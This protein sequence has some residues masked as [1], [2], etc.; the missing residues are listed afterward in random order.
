MTFTSK[1]KMFTLA[2]N[3]QS[4]LMKNSADNTNLLNQSKA[5]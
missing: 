5:F 4:N 2:N 3:S 1:K